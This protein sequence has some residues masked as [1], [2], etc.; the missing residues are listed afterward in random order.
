MASLEGRPQGEEPAGSK[1]KRDARVCFAN[2]FFVVQP[3]NLT[4]N[5]ADRHVFLLLR[6][7]SGSLP[8]IGAL[9]FPLQGG[10]IDR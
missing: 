8:S 9:Q 3:Q 4:A 5:D 7:G 10:W 1:V 6:L 2:F